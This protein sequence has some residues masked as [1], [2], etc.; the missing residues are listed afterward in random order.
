M[1]K[2]LKSY[3][4]DAAQWKDWRY[5]AM[6]WLA[7]V[8]PAFEIF[9]TKLDANTE[10][11]ESPQSDEKMK[12]GLEEATEEEEWC[13]EQLYALLVQKMEGAALAMIRNQGTHGRVRGVRAWY[14]IMREAEGQLV[15]KRDEITRNVFDSD[16]NSVAAKDV[17]ATIE[18]WESEV[19]EY[20]KLAGT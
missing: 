12:I 5:K 4:G 17:A 20:T 9:T 19:H 8:D 11:P 2:H 3:T 10:E 6:N 18:Q 15:T 16:R 1:F 7:Q 13:S 14:R